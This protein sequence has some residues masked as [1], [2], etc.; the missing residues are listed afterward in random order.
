RT[1]ACRSDL[2]HSERSD[3]PKEL[4]SLGVSI[5]ARRWRNSMRIDRKRASATFLTLLVAT[6]TACRAGTPG[7]TPT[8]SAKSSAPHDTAT[9]SPAPEPTTR[10]DSV[11]LRTD[12]SQYR[13]GEKMTLTLEN[14]SGS[15]HTLQP[16]L[17]LFQLG[18]RD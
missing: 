1:R 17:P 16:R 18:E 5:F 3:Y 14:K 10:A 2:C 9:A 13:A 15:P 7:S 12:K 6:L 8:D 4:A 11:V